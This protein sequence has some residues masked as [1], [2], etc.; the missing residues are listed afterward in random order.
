MG[1]ADL[2]AVSDVVTR[3]TC[4]EDLFGVLVGSADERLAGLKHQYKR[5][6][7]VVHPDKYPGNAAL[8]AQARNAFVK[9]TELMTRGERKI[10]AG[11]YGDK[12][13]PDAPAL[14]DPDPPP[15]KVVIA[16]VKYTL[17]RRV[18]QGD[19]ADLYECSYERPPEPKPVKKEPEEGE[20]AWARIM[21]TDGPLDEPEKTAGVLFKIVRS[22]AD[23]DLLENE[24]TILRELYPTGQTDEKYFRYLPKLL[25]SLVYAPVHKNR[26]R[27][28]L[29]T[30]YDG[31]FSLEEIRSVYPNGL[32]FRDV[33]WMY[34]RMLIGLGFAHHRGFVHGA[35]LPPHVLVHPVNHGARIVDWSYAVKHDGKARIRALSKVYRTFYAPEVERKA[36]AMPAT[37]IYM[38]TKCFVAMLG[39]D[40][41][42]GKVPDSVPQP[43]QSFIAGCL[44]ANP[45]SRPDDA[46]KLHDELKDIL[47]VVVGK[48]KYRPLAMPPTAKA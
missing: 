6:V 3:A 43:I 5:L 37:D 26:R 1:A 14:V 9:S 23:N 2:Q 33:V 29:I 46:W 42:T 11:T 10:R 20:T 48:S 28:N 47:E 38:A 31:L 8:Q 44:L 39:G 19:L 15:S 7:E 40:V 45:S 4:P 36:P 30:R 35:V 41:A 25:D 24:A 17:G 12:T 18:A 32:D 13:K 27:V 22:P 21:D 34:K 16:K